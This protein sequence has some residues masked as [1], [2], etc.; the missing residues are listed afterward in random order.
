MSGIGIGQK[1][2]KTGIRLSIGR[3][4]GSS[5]HSMTQLHLP[6]VLKLWEDNPHCPVCPWWSHTGSTC[7]RA[8][9]RPE[10]PLPAA[11]D[12]SPA[13]SPRPPCLDNTGCFSNTIKEA[14]CYSLI[15]R[16][17]PTVPPLKREAKPGV[18][19][20]TYNPAA[21]EAE[22]ARSQFPGQP[23]LL[24]RA[25]L[26]RREKGER[27][28]EKRERKKKGEGGGRRNEKEEE[29]KDDKGEGNE[30]EGR[31][32]PDVTHLLKSEAAPSPVPR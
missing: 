28:K 20:H 16:T 24:T 5:F 30:G 4:E 14:G 1:V 32:L 18:V 3:E 9:L 10:D 31:D 17:Q 22:T 27:R 15:S 21:Q 8:F 2:L 26:K 25:Y 13:F 6:R 19:T 7:R 29:K 11:F 12:C 23:G